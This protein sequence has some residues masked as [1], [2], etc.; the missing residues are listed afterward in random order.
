MTTKDLWFQVRLAGLK[1]IDLRK[2]ERCTANILMNGGSCLVLP[3]WGACHATDYISAGMDIEMPDAS[4]LQPDKIKA[5]I[6]SGMLTEAMVDESCHRIL[7]SYFSVPEDKRVPGPCGGGDCINK[8]VKTAAH[9]AL[10]RKLSAM[11]TVLLKN[12]GGLLPLSKNDLVGK[13][14]VLIGT[15]GGTDCYT[16]GSGSGAVSDHDKV[17]PIVAMKALG[18]DVTSVTDAEEAVAAAKSADLAIVFGS[19]H[20]GEG[21][22][23][24]SLDLE[25]DIDE[26][27]PSVAA[28]QPKTI[29]VLSVPGS[30]LTPWRESVPAILWNGL[31]GE[32]VGP[33]LGD[34]LFGVTPPQAKLPVTQPLKENDQGFTVKQYPGIDCKKEKCTGTNPAIKVESTYSEGQIVGYRWYD[35][36]KVVP[37]FAFGHGLTYGNHSLSGLKVSGRTVSFTLTR[38]AGV[39]CETP[40]VYIGY[41]SASVDPTVPTKVMRY[42]K[43]SCEATEQLSY[44]MTD[45]DVSNWDVESKQWTVTKGDYKVYVGVSSQDIH[46]TGSMTVV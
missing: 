18:L 44:T 17:C 13:K 41:P 9:V 19:A 16:G 39:G 15:D 29:V 31:P 8:K 11:S 7:R 6:A 2:L 33:A 46:L 38:T 26:L 27:I 35:K 22:D 5:G 21:H 40:Q 20:T 24:D 1:Q 12:E 36:H 34:I 10:A 45:Q 28:V 42:F 43:K 25:G 4:N 3:D 32:Q 14:I 30:I 23:R 37:A